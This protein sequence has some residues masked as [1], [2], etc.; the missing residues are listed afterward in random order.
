MKRKF[1][2]NGFWIKSDRRKKL[3]LSIDAGIGNAKLRGKGY[4]SQ[5]EI[6]YKPI[7]PLN[8]SLEFKRDISPIICNM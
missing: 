8:L 2:Y 7:D 6:D 1:W 3:I 5:F 4:Y